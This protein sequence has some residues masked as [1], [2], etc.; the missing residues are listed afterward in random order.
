MIALAI[1]WSDE[2]RELRIAE[3]ALKD[4]PEWS[5]D[6]EPDQGEITLKEKEQIKE[7]TA[8]KKKLTSKQQQLQQAAKNSKKNNRIL[9]QEATHSSYRLPAIQPR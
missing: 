4:E 8:P 1:K 5:V 2:R 9:Q 3:D 6:K 7:K